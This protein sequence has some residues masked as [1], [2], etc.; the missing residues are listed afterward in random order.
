MRRVKLRFLLL[1][2]AVLWPGPG[3]TCPSLDAITDL[4][5]TPDQ[6]VPLASSK[7][8]D[9]IQ[10]AYLRRV[11]PTQGTPDTASKRILRVIQEQCVAVA[12]KGRLQAWTYSDGEDSSSTWRH[13]FISMPFRNVIP[14]R[15]A[16]EDALG[17][18]GYGPESFRFAVISSRVLHLRLDLGSKKQVDLPIY[19]WAFF[20]PGKTESIRQAYCAEYGNAKRMKILLSS[21]GSPPIFGPVI[22]FP[23]SLRNCS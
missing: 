13:L 5:S 22:D 11:H 10:V 18:E 3:W 14:F 21:P 23:L 4:Q 1:V 7:Y 15:R 16:L 6:T 19:A 2:A 9:L 20:N 17:D 8:F 12:Y